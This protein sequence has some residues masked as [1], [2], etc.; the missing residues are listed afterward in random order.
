VNAQSAI[1][2]YFG[3][4]LPR[5]SGH[6]HPHASRFQSAR[7]AFLALL[8]AHRPSRVWMPWFACDSILEP[9][10]MSGVPIARYALGADFTVGDQVALQPGEWLLVVNYFGIHDDAVAQVLR[11]FP[12][13]QVIVD[14]AQ[15]WYSR[16]RPCLATL[17]SPRKFFGVPDGGY[18][19]TDLRIPE[20]CI[21][22]SGSRER[23][24]HLLARLAAGAEAGYDAFVAA[25]R[26]L[27]EQPPYRMSQLTAALL[28]SIDYEAAAHRRLQN[29]TLLHAALA[30][31]NML[32]LH[33][34]EGAVPMCYPY[35]PRRA[36]LREK[37]RAARIYVATY[38]PE[39]L[40][41]ASQAPEAD[42]ALAQEI[43]PI[44]CDQRYD[45]GDMARVLAVIDT[46]SER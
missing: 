44:P 27:A 18:L 42:R 10:R 17:Y 7:A 4:E 38:W 22:D 16:P 2:G 31:G 46:G 12:S 33:L 6:F 15:A 9:L 19:V 8:L 41:A 28:G 3:L 35:R 14:N 23:F 5:G 29:F 20:P 36:G 24:T 30:R 25:E 13:E 34:S 37:L 32:D 26:G 45:T 1:G 39:V 21:E 11:H 40:A 43:L